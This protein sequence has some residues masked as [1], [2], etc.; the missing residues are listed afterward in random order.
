MTCHQASCE[1]QGLSAAISDEAQETDKADPR[2]DECQSAEEVV[3]LF[4][5][6][7]TSPPDLERQKSRPH[8]E[9]SFPLILTSHHQVRLDH[10]LLLE[11]FPLNLRPTVALWHLEYP[12]F[13]SSSLVLLL[14]RTRIKFR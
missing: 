6:I 1:G 4:G 14:S 3:G 7:F 13:T 12:F 11:G 2:P 9:E 10:A 5:T 8:A